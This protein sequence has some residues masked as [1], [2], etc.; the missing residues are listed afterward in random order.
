MLALSSVTLPLHLPVQ[1]GISSL[2]LVPL[3]LANWQLEWLA[4]NAL[5]PLPS[6]SNEPGELETIPPVPVSLKQ[7]R[8]SVPRE[9]LQAE[10]SLKKP[11]NQQVG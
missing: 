7:L 6:L 11:Y 5:L 4:S 2:H 10:N 9:E 8:A 3:Q 1:S